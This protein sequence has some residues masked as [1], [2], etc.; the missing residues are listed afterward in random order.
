MPVSATIGA[1]VVAK[2]TRSR[3]RFS[4]QVVTPLAIY[5]CTSAR[6]P[7]REPQVKA[8]LANGSLISMKSVRH[9]RHD[10]TETCLIHGPEVCVS[11]LEAS[12]DQ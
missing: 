6:D 12:E 4:A 7:E 10:K 5:S 8:S 1:G 11:G 2:I 9:D 3:N